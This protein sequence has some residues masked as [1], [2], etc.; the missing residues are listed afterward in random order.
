MDYV[1]VSDLWLFVAS[2]VAAGLFGSSALTLGL[3]FGLRARLVRRQRRTQNFREVWQPLLFEYL[4]GER[5][6]LPALTRR[7]WADFLYLWNYLQGSVRG[8]ANE[9]LNALAAEVKL[10]SK[11]HQL[12]KR[13]SVPRR[14]LAIQALGYL[15]DETAWEKLAQL[16]QGKHTELSLT[17]AQALFRI[18]PGRAAEILLPLIVRREDWSPALVAGFFRDTD[19]QELA[20]ILGQAAL[21]AVQGVETGEVTPHQAARLVRYLEAADLKTASRVLCQILNESD[22]QEI[23]VA[24]L[25]LVQTPFALTQVRRLLKDA[26]WPVRMGAALALGRIG[27][28]ADQKALQTTLGDAEWWVRYHSARSLA[29]ITGYDA[30]AL[31]QIAA[32]QND[33]F[34]REIVKQVLAE[35]GL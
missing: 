25:K 6:A 17:A 18:N 33:P 7:D 11:A 14:L 20:E 12:L 30:A 4:D 24:C 5:Q 23:L 31:E 10:T 1:I 22:E 15:R 2:L 34:A 27:A 28:T 32:R 9:R 16:A 13:V 21:Q 8:L 19:A 26:R 29:K 35:A 3:T